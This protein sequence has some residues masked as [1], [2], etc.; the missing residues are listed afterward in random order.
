MFIKYLREK[1]EI[2]QFEDQDPEEQ[3]RRLGVV[4]SGMTLS[5]SRARSVGAG[6]IARN[7]LLEQTLLVLHTIVNYEVT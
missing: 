4:Q 7:A 1:L 5:A 6:H 3:D 2:L